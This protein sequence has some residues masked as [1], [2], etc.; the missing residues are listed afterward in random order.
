MNFNPSTKTFWD[1]TA[2]HANTERIYD[3]CHGCRRCFNLCPSFSDLFN[4]LDTDRVDGEVKKLTRTDHQKIVDDCY[5]CKL[6]FN[7]CPYTPPHQYDLDFPRLMIQTKIQR[8]RK[9]PFPL[10]DRVLVDIDRMGRFASLFAP[11]V[12][13]GNRQ[14]WIRLVIEKIFGIHRNRLLAPFAS[15]TFST[16]FK[17]RGRTD[18]KKKVVLFYTCFV[19]YNDPEIG[20]ASV[21]VLERN[22]IEV[23]VPPQECCGMPFFDTGEID[24]VLKKGTA[25]LREM[26]KWVDQG[27]DIVIPMPT[28]SLMFKKEYPDLYQDEVS[29]KVAAK[30]FDLSE[31]LM[32]LHKEGLLS[33]DFK[34][35]GLG[36]I[37]YQIPCHLRD[38]NIGYKSRDLMKLIPGT[39]V[40]VIEK[41][42]GHDGT[43]GIK[44][45]YFEASMKIAQPLLRIIQE[46]RPDR[47]M[48]DCPL[49]G[50][51]IEQG[52]GQKTAHPVQILNE[53]YKGK[54]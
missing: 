51:Q 49:A 26:E 23:L 4:A 30:S 2:L 20:K 33:L 21:E 35:S 31:Y 19:N 10:K 11:W 27:Y 6:C 47:I 22:G 1:E 45:E 53:A 40:E 25:N 34:K 41:C 9:E 16:W 42:S 3:I 52:S 39:Q 24:Q 13:W 32:K 15:Q 29:R 8:A 12:N 46:S 7:H 18:R 28:C 48:T 37:A 38:Q 54:G 44:K 14:G 43:W 50:V 5:Y 36:K 17:K